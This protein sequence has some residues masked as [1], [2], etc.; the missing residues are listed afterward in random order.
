MNSS[1]FQRRVARASQRGHC[2]QRWLLL[3]GLTAACWGYSESMCGGCLGIAL[4]EGGR[5]P[6]CTAV[7]KC[8]RAVAAQQPWGC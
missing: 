3:L 6:V 2:Q 7:M 5:L 4:R 8:S 1:M